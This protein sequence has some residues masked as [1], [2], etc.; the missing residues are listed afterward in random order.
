ML[1]GDVDPVRLRLGLRASLTRRPDDRP[2]RFQAVLTP[3]DAVLAAARGLD[4]VHLSWAALAAGAETPDEL[5]GHT[6]RIARAAP[7]PVLVDVGPPDAGGDPRTTVEAFERAGAAGIHVDDRPVAGDPASSSTDDV[8]ACIGAAAGAR[9]DEH[10]LIGVRVVA[11]ADGRLVDTIDRAR[12]CADAGADIV[13]VD[14]PETTASYLAFR[15]ALDVPLLADT[16]A[17]QHG[18]GLPTLDQLARIGMD[19]VIHPST[20]PRSPV[21]TGRRSAGLVLQEYR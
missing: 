14:E 17:V 5:A 16:K 11:P 1:S 6:A 9:R 3:S 12:A 21:V 18:T 7:L 2:L 13:V 8:V 4:G 19:A 20:S 10:F 15:A